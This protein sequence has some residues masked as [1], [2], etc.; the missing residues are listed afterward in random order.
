MKSD[1]RRLGNGRNLFGFAA[2]F[3][4]FVLFF[5]CTKPPKS[6]EKMK[7]SLPYDLEAEPIDISIPLA[8]GEGNTSAWYVE[9]IRMEPVRANGF[10][11]SVQEGGAV[12]FRDIYFNPHGHGTHTE[13]RGHITDSVHSVNQ[14]RI[15]WLMDCEVITI[16]PDVLENGDQVID[17]PALQ[18][19]STSPPEALVIRTLPNKL[20]KRTRSWSNTNPPYLTR[21]AAEWLVAQNVMHLLIDL[22]SV[23][24]EVDE[25]VLAA[26]HIFW[27]I[28]H[29]PRKEATITEFVY[30]PEHVP[31]G[32]YGLNLQTAPFEND[33]TPSRPLLLPLVNS[34]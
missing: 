23:D 7:A 19:A 33:A 10:V 27:G 18:Q 30:I 32:F 15:P 34:N 8:A 22:P 3:G 24:R 5:A 20:D 4:S 1:M 11:G 9:P 12:N 26:H 2:V 6:P 13:C 25:G 31:D 16:A 17:A 29:A 28:P 21:K 14:I